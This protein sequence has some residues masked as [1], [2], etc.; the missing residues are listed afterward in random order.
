VAELTDAD[1]YALKTGDNIFTGTNDF[2]DATIT[3]PNA[4]ND[5][6]ATLSA[7]CTQNAVNVCDLIAVFDSLS[8]RI[9]ALED[10]IG[11]MLN[12][13]TA[14]TITTS[15]ATNISKTSAT[16]GGNL[17]SA[18]T[19]TVNERGVCYSTTNHEP[20][21]D[22]TK[23]VATGTGTGAFTSS[24]SGLTQ[25]TTYYVRAYV[26][27]DEPNTYYGEAV[28]FTTSGACNGVTTISD[29][30]G[31]TY[32]T[33][34]IGDQCWMKENLRTKKFADGTVIPSGGSSHSTTAPY[35]YNP[36]NN[37]T[38]AE[39]YG[40]LYNWSAVMNGASSSSANPSGV[41][42][43]CPDGWHVPSNA[44]WT[45]MVNYVS[46]QSEFICDGN[47]SNIGKALAATTGWDT[48]G[49]SC[50]VS[51]TDMA[52]NNKTGFSALPAGMSAF[53]SYTGLG[54]FA[55]FWTA[56]QASS[57]YSIYSRTLLY[58]R[59]DVK[60]TSDNA[61]DYGSSV[62]CVRDI[63]SG[64]GS[65]SYTV[66]TVTTSEVVRTSTTS[67]TVGGTV[68]AD[69]NVAVT[70]RGVCW[71]T[72]ATPTIGGSHRSIGS[73]L[74][75]FSIELTDL[76][77]GTT[78]YVRAYATNS[79]GTAYGEEKTFVV[80]TIPL[81]VVTTSAA[82]DINPTS[83]TVGGNVTDDGGETVTARGICWST[84]S[85]PTISDQYTTN[86]TGTGSFTA[87][88]TGLT[89]S[90]TYYAR[91]YVTTGVGTAYGEEISFTTGA[92]AVPTVTT[93][94]ATSVT[95]NSAYVQGSVT[96]DGGASVTTRGICYST[97]P[98]P[99]T[100]NSIKTNGSGTGN[101]NT[102]LSGLTAGTTYY[103]R[104]YATNSQ[105]TAYGEQV[106]F[107]TLSADSKP[108]VTTSDATDVTRRG[109]YVQG[110]VTAEGGDSV[111][112][113]GICYSTSQN[114]TTSNTKKTSGYGTGDFTV[115]L[116]GLSSGIT[117]YARAYATN[118]YGT[119]YGEQVTFTT[120]T[121][122]SKPTVTT[123]NATQITQNTA[124]VQ[125]NVTDDG[126]ANVTTRGI[127]YSTSP[128]PTTSDNTRPYGSGTGSFN[129]YM[130]NLT[131]NTTYYA[132]AYATNAHGTSYGEQVTFTTL[133]MMAPSFYGLY[134]PSN[135][136]N[137]TAN[138][139][140]SIYSNG[141]AN[142]TVS[143]FC[144][145]TSNPEPSLEDEFTTGG[146]YG[147]LTGLEEN[148]TYYLRAY[149]TNSVGTGYSNSVSFTT[150]HSTV[151]T[152]ITSLTVLTSTSAKVGGIAGFD[153][154]SDI[155]ERGVCW[156]TSG[157]PTKSDNFRN[158]GD[159]TGS[160]DTELTGLTEGVQYYVRAYAINSK[161][162]GYGQEMSFTAE[163]ASIFTCGTSTVTDIEGNTYPTVQIGEQCWMKEN[164]RSK[165]YADGTTISEGEY[166]ISDDY[167]NKLWYYLNNDPSYTENHY[168][169]L[170]NWLA[171]SKNDVYDAD[172]AYQTQ[173]VAL[174][175]I[176]PDGWHL[177]N[178]AE[179][180]QLCNYARN[181]G[182]SCGEYDWATGKAFAAQT[183]WTSN[184]DPC[185]PGYDMT[186]NNALGFSALPNGYR[187]GSNVGKLAA[188]WSASLRSMWVESSC[189]NDS[190]E[191]DSAVRC[192]RN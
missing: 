25:A 163:A 85:N 106:T 37:A 78:Y 4:I 43:I 39:T 65:Q 1:N 96:A 20:T 49:G 67:A 70:E 152:V 27:T 187:N 84:S 105:G 99:T 50:N 36:D 186:T 93:S 159:G 131:A 140:G 92:L 95:R 171:A 179:W 184:S 57:I 190:V 6:S 114:P 69:G 29:I 101:F 133:P 12:N 135:I 119:S 14:P 15:E 79:Q 150:R 145:S 53:G 154:Y 56:T 110:N 174:Q 151:P 42:G 104:A 170:Y 7:S 11:S 107:T 75:S 46:G 62:R 164:M 38:Y 5:L 158:L 137:T 30:D 76:T 146:L 63:V 72:H 88:L 24:L 13:L 64:G 51:N 41:Q 127:C 81:P 47:S 155:T 157:S 189:P 112:S 9:S 100:S 176:C 191:L 66:P 71:S 74:G 124:Y 40:L 156:N 160:F 45:Q 139:Y 142:P 59:T 23:V 102:Y 117:Y 60:T 2:T 21:V 120:L 58:N 54:T 80:T 123:S 192:I 103:A 178:N 52:T 31:N 28:T 126:G 35:W 33:I 83:A 167:S 98:N 109:A 116:T 68:T 129:Q 132:R 165:T 44:E 82:T 87:N 10:I 19:T 175:G 121:T 149:A 115:Q 16:V 128:N 161:G 26:K 118:S 8:R 136:T 143:G 89:P 166:T 180:E 61:S 97:S 73:G 91:A 144:Y 169:L 111:T 147:T 48:Y 34:G 138:V 177:P 94:A 90:T 181:N 122:D 108:T 188:F 153:G 162:I 173:G 183:G 32:N 55:D 168:G 3:V 148:T 22:D 86:G 182:Y 134:K 185:H 130:Y 77:I 141:G 18:G 113:R 172:Y 17:I 125:G